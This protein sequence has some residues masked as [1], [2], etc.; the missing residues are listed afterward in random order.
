ET[1]NSQS[2]LIDSCS[3]LGPPVPPASANGVGIVAGNGTAV[4]S[5]DVTGYAHGIRHQ[6]IGLTVH[7]GRFEVNDAAIVVGLDENGN[8]FQSSG[9]DIAGLSM[10]ANQTGIY[11]AVGAGGSIRGISIGGGVPM[12]YGLRLRSC[13]DVVVQGV[14]VSGAQGYSG[15][16][17]AIESPTRTVLMSVFSAT[18]RAWSLPADQSQLT[19]LQTNKS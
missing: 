1:F 8:G 7:G 5:T 14:V 11:I 13:Q 2:I 12:T 9:F 6:N 18:T 19:F 3:L 17:V 10:E 16:G 4:I 15:A